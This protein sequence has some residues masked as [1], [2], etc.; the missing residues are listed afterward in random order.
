MQITI[1]FVGGKSEKPRDIAENGLLFDSYESANDYR[2]DTDRKSK[3][4]AAEAT[5]HV[6]SMEEVG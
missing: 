2:L 1:Y 6:D 3:V 4:Y 5:V